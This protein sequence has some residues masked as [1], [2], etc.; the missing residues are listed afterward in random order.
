MKLD[1]SVIGV[2]MKIKKLKMPVS[3]KSRLISLGINE[4]DEIVVESF[5]LFGGSV[6]L[7]AKNLKVV[8][9]KELAEKIEV[10]NV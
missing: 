5:S 8:M 1:K 4:G 6:L 3:E 7:K 9:R 10:E 2:K